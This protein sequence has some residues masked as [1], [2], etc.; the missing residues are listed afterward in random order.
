MYSPIES[1]GDFVFFGD[2]VVDFC[3]SLYAFFIKLDNNS[4]NKN[5]KINRRK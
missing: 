4:L 5:G 2:G 1:E 3:S